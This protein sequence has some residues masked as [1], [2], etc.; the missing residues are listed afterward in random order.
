MGMGGGF[1]LTEPSGMFLD[2]C[3]RV[4][5]EKTAQIVNAQSRSAG[6]SLSRGYAS[7]ARANGWPRTLSR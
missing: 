6:V 2:E 1:L 7:D 5:H 3:L 4:T